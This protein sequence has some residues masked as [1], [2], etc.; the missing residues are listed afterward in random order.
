MMMNQLTLNSEYIAPWAIGKEPFP[1][2]LIWK[3]TVEFDSIEIRLPENIELQDILNIM[4]YESSEGKIKFTTFDMLSPDYF[5][6]ILASK[7][8]FQDLMKEIPIRIIFSKNNDVLLDKTLIAR[9]VRPKIS[10]ENTDHEIILD[11]TSN[12]KQLLRFKVTHTGLGKVTVDFT[13]TTKGRIISE[14]DSLYFEVLREIER[15]FDKGELKEDESIEEEA[16]LGISFD[17]QDLQDHA[18][19]ILKMIESSDSHPELNRELMLK[20]AELVKD[21]RSKEL[22]IKVIYAK[23]QRIIISYLLYYFEK[24]PQESIELPAGKI[25]VNLGAEIDEIDLELKYRDS[26]DNVYESAKA[27]VKITDKRTN[28]TR[29]QIP[30]NLDW[31]VKP[32][33]LYD[34]K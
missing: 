26:L 31:H 6:L 7:E 28:K 11:D 33:V 13:A 15:D 25:R 32:L 23:V 17:Q 5:S 21:E 14:S 10:I 34:K 8:T 9:I 30:I 1:L 16:A 4:K 2:H 18:T 24:Y 19:K 12:L 20:L 27:T 29:L 3:P 22:L